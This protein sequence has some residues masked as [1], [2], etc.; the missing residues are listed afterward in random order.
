MAKEK[1]VI[2]FVV[3]P[4]FSQLEL[5]GCQGFLKGLELKLYKTGVV[6]L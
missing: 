5:I 3:Y 1:N 4:R 2:V 6:G